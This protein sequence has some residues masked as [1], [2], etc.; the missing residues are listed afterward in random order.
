M[1]SFDIDEYIKGK[2]TN[3][4]KRVEK[5]LSESFYEELADDNFITYNN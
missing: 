4:Q 3:K 5:I 1:E 2:I